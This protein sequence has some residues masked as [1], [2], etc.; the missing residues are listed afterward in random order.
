MPLLLLSQADVERLL[1]PA[2]MLDV[3]A[4]GFADLSSGNV[5]APGRN[6]VE[7]AGGFLLAMPGWVPGS[8]IGVKLVAAFHGNPA[9][10]L[11]GHQ[12]LIALFDPDTGTPLVV[13][14]GTHVTAL[15]TA[16]GAALTTRLLA[17]PDSPVLAVIGGGVQ[18][19]SHA[20]LLPLVR[21]IAEIRVWARDKQGAERVAAVDERCRVAA[22]AEEAVRDADI[23]CLCT[24][25]TEPPVRA[26]WIAPGTHVTSVG[27][28]PPGGELDRAL[29]ER[30]HLF[31]E[32]RDAFAPPPVGN[33]ELQGIDP[34]RGTEVGEVILGLRPGRESAEEIT[35]YKSMGH[36][37]EDVVTAGLVYQAALAE[38]IGTSFAMEN[39]P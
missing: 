38:G 23:V 21:D 3:L 16:G 25:A 34:A 12:A 1:D 29:I 6:G 36:A 4:Q 26:D 27:F 18:A 14:D 31:V 5:V 8:P 20:H 24:S 37:M 19:V 28:H 22:T 7:T 30:G 33:A 15:R 2:A 10:G 9:L 11:P 13:M 39:R 17:R 35:V 32:S